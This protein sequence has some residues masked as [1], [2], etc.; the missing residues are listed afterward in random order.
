MRYNSSIIHQENNMISVN[1]KQLGIAAVLGLLV[2]ATHGHHFATAFHLP[3]ATWAVFFLAG[4][5]LRR[6]WVFAALLAEVV[7]LDYVAVTVGGVSSYCVSPAY[8]FM[9]PAYGAL[10]L[11]GRWFSRRYSFSLNA[12]PAMA[13]SAVVGATLAELFSSGGFYF[14][15]GRFA[16]TSLT[17][18]A[19]RIAQ[20]FP[21]TLSSFAFW[22]GIAM[23]VHVAFTLAQ[24]GKRHH[25]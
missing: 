20:Y 6:G 7:L 1:R 15:S 17:E 12:L 23:I 8:G 21:Q 13:G 5:Y 25:A 18:F 2:A 24:S 14:F 22:M 3:P 4:F 10:W 19:G 9:L 11:A 16:A